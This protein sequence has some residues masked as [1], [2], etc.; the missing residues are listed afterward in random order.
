MY[1]ES[2]T[3]KKICGDD[4]HGQLYDL[5]ELFKVGGGECPDKRIISSWEILSI[6]DSY[7]SGRNFFTVTSSE[8]SDTVSRSDYSYSGADDSSSVVDDGRTSD[9][10]R[11]R[12]MV[13]LRCKT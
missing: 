9:K 13:M 2:K 8:G 1:N 6:E 5:V 3:E 7:Y 12:G 10:R 11:R 4:I